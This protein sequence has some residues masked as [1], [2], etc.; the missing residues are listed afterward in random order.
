MDYYGENAKLEVVEGA[1][2]GFERIEHRSMLLD[3]TAQ[4]MIE[5]LK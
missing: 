4:F 1:G 5:Q 2:H 3:Q